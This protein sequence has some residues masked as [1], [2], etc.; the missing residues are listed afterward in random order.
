MEEEACPSAEAQEK[1]DEGSKQISV[2]SPILRNVW[3][4][5]WTRKISL[6]NGVNLRDDA[7]MISNTGKLSLV[8]RIEL[9]L[10]ASVENIG[11]YAFEPI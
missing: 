1:K 11:S 9:P 7:L 6:G 10:R 2:S 4:L 3:V 5:S 8:F